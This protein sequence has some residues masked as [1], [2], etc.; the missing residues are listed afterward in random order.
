MTTIKKQ[1]FKIKFFKILIGV[2]VSLIT[3]VSLGSIMFFLISIL[4]ENVWIGLAICTG[5]TLLGSAFYGP[6]AIKDARKKIEELE[7][8]KKG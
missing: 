4:L 2:T 5:L 7:E 6:T 8:A 3:L 1:K